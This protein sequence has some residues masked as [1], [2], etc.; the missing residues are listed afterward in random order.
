VIRTAVTNLLLQS[1]D[2]STTWT[3]T[4]ATVTTNQIASPNGTVTADLISD[5]GSTPARVRQQVSVV[6]GQTYTASI[7]L[8]AGSQDSVFWREDNEDLL[9]VGVN[10]A[11]G[12]ITSGT[13]T[14]EPV[15]DGWY[16]VSFSGS[17]SSSGFWPEVRLNSPGTV[18][19]WGAQ[20]EQSSTVGQY[21]KTTT[22]INSAP[23]FDHD[24]TTGESLG[25]LVEESR[26]NL[27]TYSEASTTYWGSAG[28]GTTITDVT[29]NAFGRFNG[30]LVTDGGADWNGINSALFSITNGTSY[31]VTV[32]AKY[33]TANNIRV[34]LRDNSASTESR[35]QGSPGSV[36]VTTELAGTIS[37]V[38][39]EL[40]SDGTVKITFVVTAN[41]TTTN[42][43]Y[44]RVGPASTNNSNVTAYAVQVEAGS[45]PTSYIPT[46]GSTVTRAADVT[47]ITGRNFG[48]VNLLPYSE[49]FD[50]N[51]QA[52][53]S[54]TPNAIIAPNGQLTADK[55]VITQTGHAYVQV[56]STSIST[57]NAYGYIDLTTGASVK[58]AGSWNGSTV[59]DV[60]NDWWYIT[61]TSD[62]NYT[63]SF[64]AKKGE[65]NYATWQLYTVARIG[66]SDATSVF[67][68]S[69]SGGAY[70]WGA[71]LE[72]GST[73][74]DYI[75]SDVNWT[76][77][78]SN[79]WYY[80]VNGT[81]KKSSYNLLLRSEEFDNGYWSLQNNSGSASKGSA[82]IIAAP[83]GTVTGDEFISGTGQYDG[84]RSNSTSVPDDSNPYTASV[85]LKAGGVTSFRLRLRFI[86][87][88]TADGSVFFNLST[89]SVTSESS[90]TGTITSVGN[91]WY[92][93]TATRSNNGTGNTNAQIFIYSD[94]QAGNF[95][96]WGAQLEKGTYAGDYAKTTTTAAS[97]ARTAA[98]LPDGN[99]NFVSAG[100][101]LLEGAG[102][103]LI[104]HS[105]SFGNWSQ[106][107]PTI[108]PN[109]TTAPDG[110]N[111]A[112]LVT[113]S[114]ASYGGLIRQGTTT[115]VAT[116]NT[117]SVYAKAGTHDTIGLRITNDCIEI[118]NNADYA[119]FNLVT[120]IVTTITPR[121]GTINQL[122]MENV[123]DGWYRCVMTYTPAA[124]P[125]ASLADIA[126]V[127]SSTG[128]HQW[129]GTG[130]VLLWGAQFEHNA[131]PTSYIPT[132]GS[133]ATRA[134]DV[135]TSAAT[136]GNSWYEQSEGTVFNEAATS[137]STADQ[138]INGFSASGTFGSSVYV[139]KN[140]SNTIALFGFDAGLSISLQS[141]TTNVP[142]KVAYGFTA[143]T[144]STSATMNGGAIADDA[145]TSIS[146]SM[147]RFVFGSAPWNP[148]SAVWNGTI[149]R[150]T[151]WPTRL[152]NDTLQTI[153][154]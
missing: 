32:F 35:V 36:S 79:A 8:K 90:A 77:R 52:K 76:S 56:Y 89:G 40:K 81:L 86:G 91:D 12:Q 106:V 74:T 22:A 62:T 112:T 5:N 44:I 152:S 61:V 21:V 144:G 127:D 83:D 31:A 103:N 126:L 109:Y 97:T 122:Y 102:T 19:L 70:L 69:G 99:G 73:A 154:T 48:S 133:T 120:G 47:S 15:G 28:A 94:Q 49:E 125:G 68:G 33:G 14:I 55:L 42:N 88:T 66:V 118:S 53:L 117:L 26:T 104:L 64:Y 37:N 96:L 87:G 7:Y 65:V 63:L 27:L 132:S 11:T 41:S 46:E 72:E 136:F 4:N 129:Q 123:G 149:K 29:D 17:V 116:E 130:N 150:L 141:V 147:D 134:A 145:N 121:S 82:N 39:E 78:V 60:G 58:E 38:T 138:I 113:G 84:V 51:P 111:T 140:T 80:D 50:Q 135:S 119:R 43:H 45:F 107:N 85:Y 13:G 16:R 93:V 143:G 25:L 153:T 142:A 3:T 24:P 115:Y 2:F 30:V 71:Q 95:Y 124:G 108:T 105:E 54:V 98:Y 10:L 18:Y 101:L 148:G 67:N 75:K 34:A 110:T 59:T 151:Y 57:S 131:Y 146:T 137:T 114:G 23:R 92:R 1:E 9:A 100:D 139:F 20:L 6:S 128:N